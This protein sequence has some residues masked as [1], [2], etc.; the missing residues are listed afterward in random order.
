M[1]EA[2]RDQNHVHSILGVLKS[3]GTT[4]VPI[5]ASAAHRMRVEDGVGGSDNGPA[6]ADRDQNHVPTMIAVSDADGSTPV[7]L[8]ADAQGRLLV[9]TT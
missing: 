7:V 8:Y 4:P 2:V 6:N 5:Q 3:D 1:A 9:Q